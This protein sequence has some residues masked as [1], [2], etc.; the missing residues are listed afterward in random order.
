MHHTGPALG[1]ALPLV[2]TAAVLA[3]S[4]SCATPGAPQQQKGHGRLMG[5]CE[6]RT[7]LDQIG[8]RF[9]EFGPLASTTWC[10]MVP[11]QDSRVPGPTDV[12]LF[13]VLTPQD[14]ATVRVYLDDP[15]YAFTP[16]APEDVP[17]EIGASLPPD[18]EWVSSEK[19]TRAVTGG[20]YDGDFLLDRRSGRV[21]FDCLDPHRKDTPSPAVTPG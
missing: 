7:E 17:A 14:P 20:R 21:L 4:T 3:A 5:V 1:R 16:S 9:P 11:A 15:S 19:L 10:G 13:G 2:A 6:A 18:A 8:A 12:R